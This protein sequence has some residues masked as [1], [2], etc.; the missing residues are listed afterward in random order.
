MKISLV[1]VK[2][3]FVFRY[4]ITFFTS[5]KFWSLGFGQESFIY[6]VIKVCGGWG[7]VGGKIYQTMFLCPLHQLAFV[8]ICEFGN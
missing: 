6:F 4:V 1:F 7:G 8:Q 5:Y 3:V 2:N